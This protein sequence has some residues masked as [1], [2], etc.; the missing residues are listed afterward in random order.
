M[1][2]VHATRVHIHMHIAYPTRACGRGWV[3]GCLYCVHFLPV[4]NLWFGWLSDPLPYH[5]THRVVGWYVFLPGVFG[6]RSGG[7]RW[8]LSCAHVSD[9]TLHLYAFET[10]QSLT[11]TY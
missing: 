2:Q 5:I 11:N 4:F 3:R 9:A 10:P 6:V 8:V 1:L 7:Q